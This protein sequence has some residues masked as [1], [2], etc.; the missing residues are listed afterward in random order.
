MGVQEVIAI[1]TVLVGGGGLWKF[2]QWLITDTREARQKQ[3]NEA[4]ERALQEERAERYKT[5][6]AA[7][8]AQKNAE[9]T[10]VREDLARERE[11]SARYQR[12]VDQQSEIIDR[13]S[14]SFEALSERVAS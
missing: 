10:L 12:K 5:E 2:I 4:V 6:S 14:R 13:L 3:V 9:L 7:T 11:Q 8:I 1:L